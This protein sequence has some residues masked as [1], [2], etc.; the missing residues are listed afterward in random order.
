MNCP[1]CGGKTY[2]IDTRFSEKYSPSIIRRRVCYKC[3][4]RFST[5]EV[6]PQMLE[7][8]KKA[9]DTLSKIKKFMKEVEA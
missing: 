1:K 9:Q 7:Y 5:Y 2:V 6:M 3:R 4:S 8:G